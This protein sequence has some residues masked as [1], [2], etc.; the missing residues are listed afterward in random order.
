MLYN[1][2]IKINSNTECRKVKSAV[3]PYKAIFKE[4]KR[5]SITCFLMQVQ[6]STSAAKTEKLCIFV[7]FVFLCVYFSK[8]F[9]TVHHS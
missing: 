9:I 4:I 8:Q 6:I 3:V 1:K 7:V 2:I 5:L